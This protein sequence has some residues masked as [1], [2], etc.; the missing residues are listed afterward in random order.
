MFRGE[1]DSY[2]AQRTGW[3]FAPERARRNIARQNRSAFNDG[4]FTDAHPGQDQTMRPDKDV[5]I[6]HHFF[7]PVCR[8]LR[9]PMQ[10]RDDGRSQADGRIVANRDGFRVKL[11]EVNVLADPDVTADAGAAQRSEEHTS[12]LQSHSFIS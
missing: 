5:P 10:M 12:E 1:R 3:R 9:P 4:S 11:V 6:D 2:V 8:A 7:V